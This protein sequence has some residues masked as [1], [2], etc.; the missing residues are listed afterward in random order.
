MR[1]DGVQPSPGVRQRAF[2]PPFG[3]D[4]ARDALDAARDDRALLDQDRASVRGSIFVAPFTSKARDPGL[5]MAADI[6]KLEIL[7]HESVRARGGRKRMNDLGVQCSSSEQ[8][9]NGGP[10]E[11]QAAIPSRELSL[12]IDQREALLE[13]RRRE[14]PVVHPVNGSPAREALRIHPNKK[15]SKPTCFNQPNSNAPEIAHAG[16]LTIH[17]GKRRHQ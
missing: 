8:M 13:L 17:A 14:R 3:G 2:R 12:V 4:V 7:L 5:E 6:G 9:A 10:F 15:C 16:H 11:F 1:I